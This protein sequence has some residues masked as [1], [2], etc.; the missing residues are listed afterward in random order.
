MICP[1][2]NELVNIT[3]ES[4]K[5]KGFTAEKMTWDEI[6]IRN[7]STSCQYVK[8]IKIQSRKEF[9]RINTAHGM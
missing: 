8:Q 3:T 4:E 6:L 1:F 7:K 2:M 9:D 5:V